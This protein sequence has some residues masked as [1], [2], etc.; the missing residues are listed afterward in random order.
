[1]KVQGNWWGIFNSKG[2]FE[3]ARKKNKKKIL[4]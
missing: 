4:G 3:S 1:M 2:T